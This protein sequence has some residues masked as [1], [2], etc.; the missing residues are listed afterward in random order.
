MYIESFDGTKIYY[1]IKKESDPFLI[2]VHGWANNWTT[3]QKEIEFFQNKGASTLTLDLR[4]HGQSDK[5]EN[6]EQYNLDCFAKDI[7]E[8][9]KKEQIN[10]FVLIG[11]SMGGMVCLDY[12]KLAQ[13]NFKMPSALI[14]CD[15]TSKIELKDERIKKISPFI[16]YLL[17]FIISHETIKEQHFQ[18]LENIDLNEYKDSS[19]F[20]IF[21]QGLYNTPLKSV[22]SCM[23]AMMNFNTESVL[24]DINIPTLIIEG[25]EDRI[26][27][28]SSARKML[29]KIKNSEINIIPKARHFVNLV[30]DKVVDIHILEFLRKHKLFPKHRL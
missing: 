7:H 26:T 20:S 22:F 17:D 12:Y 30:A 8:I 29:N 4:G 6:K 11:H 23:E 18:Y 3:W 28:E 9:V 25:S 14:L 10:N 5:P 15:T 2:F 19:D 21:Y 24:K 13:K 16:R 1:R 27:P